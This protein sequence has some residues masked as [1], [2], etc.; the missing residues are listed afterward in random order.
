MDDFDSLLTQVRET[1]VHR[2]TAPEMYAEFFRQLLRDSLHRNASHV[3]LHCS[4]TE[5]VVRYR[6]LDK[7]QLRAKLP[8][9][10]S[11]GLYLALKQH[12]HIDHYERRRTQDGLAVYEADGGKRAIRVSILPALHGPAAV[13]TWQ[14]HDQQC[15][16]LHE[17][18]LLREQEAVFSQM[19]RHQRGLIVLSGNAGRRTVG[20]AALLATKSDER[21]VLSLEWGPSRPLP[22][23]LQCD[24]ASSSKLSQ[25]D[26][27]EAALRRR[28]DAIFVERSLPV[29]RELVAAARGDCLVIAPMEQCFEH[30]ID[31]LECVEVPRDTATGALLGVVE[32]RLIPRN[33]PNCVTTY[34]PKASE[35]QQLRIRCEDTSKLTF[36][37]GTGC[38]ECQRTGRSGFVGVQEVVAMN[39]ELRTM[40]V[41]NRP[42]ETIRQH[43]LDRGLTT[44][45]Q[46]AVQKLLAGEIASTTA[47]AYCQLYWREPR[48]WI[49][50]DP[51]TGMARRT[52]DF[53][54][55]PKKR[56]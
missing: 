42:S 41:Q 37:K 5:L 20:H 24:C 19:L 47:I 23:I 28:P 29:I 33:C 32:Q 39:D 38:L 55:Q 16:R 31:V 15:R 46:S 43:L 1:S 10:A 7:L 6:V 14:K 8:V 34:T 11:D 17:L 3:H 18:G 35:L 26:W 51:D 9:E 50:V 25:L 45:Y 4:S 12:C 40:F 49:A 2:T 54:P 48:Q 30:V 44:Y 27:I 53:E 52:D 21:D 13:L 56:R 36:A 22:G